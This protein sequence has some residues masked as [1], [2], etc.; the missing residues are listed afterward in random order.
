LSGAGTTVGLDAHRRGENEVSANNGDNS[1]GHR[2]VTP[3]PCSLRVPSAVRCFGSGTLS[4]SYADSSMPDDRRVDT[5]VV[6][7]I[8]RLGDAIDAG[9]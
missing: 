5:V 7:D 8:D 2:P 1:V 4:R 6:L 9:G 3:D